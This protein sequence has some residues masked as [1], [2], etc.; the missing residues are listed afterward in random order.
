VAFRRTARSIGDQLWEYENIPLQPLIAHREKASRTALGLELFLETA[1]VKGITFI[2]ATAK[3]LGL[4]LG[5][6]DSDVSG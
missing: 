4:R 3:Y 6:Y 1:V 2:P 5:L